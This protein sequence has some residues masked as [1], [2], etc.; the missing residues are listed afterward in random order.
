MGRTF[1]EERMME[2]HEIALAA[3]NEHYALQKVDE[4]T[5]LLCTLNPNDTVVEIGCDAGGTSWAI[6]QMGV[7]RYIGI[8]LPGDKFSSGLAWQ[9]DSSTAM[10]WGDSH[11]NKVRNL[12][13][14]VL[15][16]DKI[17]VLIIDGDHTYTGVADD[18]RMYGKLCRGI[19]VFH[20]VCHHTDPDVGVDKFFS[21]VR[22]RY[23]SIDYV[24]P[25]D[26]TWG[27]IGV[28]FVANS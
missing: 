24:S 16:G 2:A 9:G 28:L 27:G 15:D 22:Q 18:F 4:L 10:I 3:V 6:Q 20:D 11:S 8:D 23:G 26:D 14:D 5:F 13:I 12:L 7:K 1:N 17:D 25:N 21:E 19:V